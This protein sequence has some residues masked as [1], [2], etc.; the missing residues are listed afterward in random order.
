MLIQPER[1]VDEL[2]FEP[3][4]IAII[5]ASDDPAKISGRPLDYLRRF[6]FAG[7]IYPVNANREVVQG[8]P[9]FRSLT[10]IGVPV[11]LALVVTPAASVPAALIECASA[12][13]GIAVVFASGFSE[14]GGAD[15]DALQREL[16]R[17]VS[18]TSLRVIGPNCLGAFAVPTSTFATFSS[19]FDEASDV[20]DDPIGLVSQSGA[21]GSFI[22][23]TLVGCGAGVRYFANTGNE[24]DVTV[25]EVLLNL[26]R[27]DDVRMAI[28][29]IEGLRDPALLV[30]AAQTALDS[31]KPL[32]VLKAGRT[33]EGQRAVAAH[34][35]SV[36][37]IDS[38]FEDIVRRYGL[39]RVHGMEDAVD[40]VLAFRPERRCAGRRLTIVTLSG[41]AAALATDAA[42]EAGLAVE[43]WNGEA[44][45][46][47][48]T[49]L[50]SFGSSANP[51]DLTGALLN[52]PAMLAAVLDSVSRHDRTDMV[53][54]VLGN[55]DRGSEEIV[56]CLRRAYATTD[57]PFAVS[58]T[59][60]SGRP[61]QKLLKLGIPT[62][63]DPNRA[64][65]A[66][67]HLARHTSFLADEGRGL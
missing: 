2:L 11:D 60:G 62:Y 21:V 28:G 49:I 16:D 23:S 22:Y 51:L 61:R 48:A 13:V 30:R 57:K 12:G 14:I 3:R 64:V 50:P 1:L 40:A 45:Q 32:I 17:I 65:R 6:G 42:V 25:P 53:L 9:A 58:W 46:D 34:T 56:E 38:E 15:A 7:K 18:T 47:M 27:R 59:G 35:A 43:E 4:S 5:G 67:S 19:A 29:H 55:A 52:D 20:S 39:V 41:G 33:S 54:V 63:T 10:D 31:A 8:V 44:R 26:L 36:A 66:L 37:G 24:S